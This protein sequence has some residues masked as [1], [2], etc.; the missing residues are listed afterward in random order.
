MTCCARRSV[1][2]QSTEFTTGH[3]M[4][5]EHRRQSCRTRFDKLHASSR[6]VIP[7]PCGLWTLRGGEVPRLRHCLVHPSTCTP[8]PLPPPLDLRRGLALRLELMGAVGP[9]IVGALPRPPQREPPPPG[10]SL[11]LAH[12]C[13]R[14]LRRDFLIIIRLSGFPPWKRVGLVRSSSV[15]GVRWLGIC[16]ER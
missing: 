8:P 11:E 2:Q 16:T 12:I 9:D 1:P 6:A 3:V 15:I 13:A 7:A 4:R 10:A 5:R 14:R